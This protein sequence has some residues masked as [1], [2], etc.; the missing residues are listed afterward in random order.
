[1][2]CRRCPRQATDCRAPTCATRA[3][4][5]RHQGRQTACSPSEGKGKRQRQTESGK[6][7][8]EQ[9]VEAVT[10]GSEARVGFDLLFAASGRRQP[11]VDHWA[12]SWSASATDPIVSCTCTWSCMH[13]ACNPGCCFPTGPVPPL[14][15]HSCMASAIT[16]SVCCA[17]CWS[18]SHRVV[19]PSVGES[20]AERPHA[21]HLSAVHAKSVVQASTHG[22]EP[23]THIL[24]ARPDYSCVP[25][26][27]GVVGGSELL[28]ISQIS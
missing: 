10:A 3:A 18:V 23:E 1:M 28:C 19:A 27:R 8:V 14:E 25:L 20:R 6:R 24:R 26:G 5:I 15:Q 13:V 17:V 22:R 4:R 7:T 12:I 21:S 11:R 16:P 2:S 9:A